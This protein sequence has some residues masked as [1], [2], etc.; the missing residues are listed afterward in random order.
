MSRATLRIA[1]C[2]TFANTA[3][4]SSLK[5]VDPMR[6]APSE[7]KVNSVQSHKLQYS[8]PNIKEPATTQTV[9]PAVIS[10]LRASMIFLNISGTWTLRT[11]SCHIRLELTQRTSV[12]HLRGNEQAK[13]QNHSSAG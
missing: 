13:A 6:A 12:P 1:R 3:L 4:S 7:L 2:P 8:H 10:I 9:V 5:S 11:W